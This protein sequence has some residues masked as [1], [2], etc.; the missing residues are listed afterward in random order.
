[1][2]CGWDEGSKVKGFVK[3]VGKQIPK[4]EG[5]DRNRKQARVK[6]AT[7]VIQKALTRNQDNI[8]IK[9]ISEDNLKARSGLKVTHW[10]PETSQ[11]F[12]YTNE[13]KGEVKPGES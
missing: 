3:G 13:L 12:K 2:K 7:K 10:T 5:K 1:M 11:R 9:E 8:E 4:C 6:R